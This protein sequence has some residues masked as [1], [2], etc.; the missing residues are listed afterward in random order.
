MIYFIAYDLNGD[1]GNEKDILA[2]IERLGSTKI[3]MSNGLLVDYN[4]TSDELYDSVMPQLKPGDRIFIN[5]VDREKYA[6][7]TYK[8]D[9]VWNW[10]RE[11]FA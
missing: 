8:A 9:G 5:M 10:L 2:V 1:D 11:R 3:C 7:R 4:G 6:G